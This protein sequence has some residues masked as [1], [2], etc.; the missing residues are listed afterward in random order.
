MQQ[1]VAHSFNRRLRHRC[2][3]RAGHLRGHAAVHPGHRR[4]PG[5]RL[6][7]GADDLHAGDRGRAEV[8]RHHDVDAAAD[9]GFG[10]QLVDLLTKQLGGEIDVCSADGVDVKVR[11]PLEDR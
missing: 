7:H 8:E 9:D 4:P 3:R 1:N 11:F 6:D 5:H 10:L 2:R